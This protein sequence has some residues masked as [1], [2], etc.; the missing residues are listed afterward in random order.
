MILQVG[1]AY[2]PSLIQSAT[3]SP[4]MIVVVLV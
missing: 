1:D 3:R 4:I 2:L